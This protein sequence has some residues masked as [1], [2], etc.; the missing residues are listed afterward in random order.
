MRGR[1]PIWVLA[2]SLATTLASARGGEP[3]DVELGVFFGYG[4]LDDF[5]S[6]QLGDLDPEDGPLAGGRVG[7]WFNQYLNV[8]LAFQRMTTRTVVEESLPLVDTDLDID[9][10]RINLVVTARPGAKIRR[11]SRDWRLASR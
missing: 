9:T 2:L 5:P 11:I 1:W 3:G 7:Y 8:E 4:V 10:A 6:S